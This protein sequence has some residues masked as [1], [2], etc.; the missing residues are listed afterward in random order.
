MKRIS[1]LW[2][3]L[4]IDMLILAKADLVYATGSGFIDTLRFFNP[5]I[6]IA[7]L[8]GRWLV[9]DFSLGRNSPNGTPIPEKELF[10]KLNKNPRNLLN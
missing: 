3:I 8:D 6:K 10:K 5:S 1:I 7:S 2:D 4:K 9:K